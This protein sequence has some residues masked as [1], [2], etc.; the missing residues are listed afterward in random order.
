[1]YSENMVEWARIVEEKISG[2][3]AAI[4]PKTKRVRRERV[5]AEQDGIRLR[6]A[7]PSRALRKAEQK[8]KR[9]IDRETLKLLSLV[10]QNR[11]GW[12]CEY[13]SCNRPSTEAHHVYSKEIKVVR[14]DEDDCI[15]TC[16]YHHTMCPKT[17]AHRDPNYI[18]T[19]IAHNVRTP[20]WYYALT[21]RVRE[22]V[23][24]DFDFVMY[25]HARLTK[26][27]QTELKNIVDRSR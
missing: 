18:Q 12:K 17:A 4:L 11:A 26:I 1:M 9:R 27:I 13:P 15:A 25:H 23:K 7:K 14:Y 19:I 21:E 2:L 24:F 6:F 16:S 22:T 5:K 10:V 8:T 20:A 3:E